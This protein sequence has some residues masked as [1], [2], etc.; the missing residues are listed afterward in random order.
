MCSTKISPFHTLYHYGIHHLSPMPVISPCVPLISCPG[1][2]Q[3]AHCILPLFMPYP[4]YRTLMQ[5]T[6]C[7]HPFHTPPMPVCVPILLYPCCPCPVRHTGHSCTYPPTP[8]SRHH[9]AAGHTIPSYIVMQCTNEDKVTRFPRFYILHNTGLLVSPSPSLSPHP[10]SP[11][12]SIFPLSSDLPHSG[13]A[14][15]TVERSVKK[16]HEMSGKTHHYSLIMVQR[17][18]TPMD[19][20]QLV[21]PIRPVTH[22]HVPH[23]VSTLHPK[24]PQFSHVTKSFHCL[25]PAP[26]VPHFHALLL[27]R[28]YHQD[29]GSSIFLANHVV[30]TTENLQGI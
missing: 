19:N 30:Y 20:P 3:C 29:S 25:L 6:S 15:R 4:P 13:V 27:T 12:L 14:Y 26:S 23:I 2:P 7:H 5:L 17:D 8:A 11:L 9:S 18:K 21:G 16:R 24:D 1:V 28:G 22:S 10:L